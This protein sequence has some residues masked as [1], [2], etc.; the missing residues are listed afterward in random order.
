MTD[1]S[2]SMCEKKPWNLVRCKKKLQ[3]NESAKKNI[4]TSKWNFVKEVEKEKITK[5]RNSS[6]SIK[7][8]DWIKQKEN[9]AR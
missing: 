1:Q 8:N 7:K 5:K 6:N 9:L 2:T 4:V 3:L